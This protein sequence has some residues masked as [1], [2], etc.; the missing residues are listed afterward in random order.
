VLHL[1]Q[2]GVGELVEVER[3]ER[4]RHPNRVGGLGPAHP[5]A[6]LCYV[7]VQVTAHRIGQQ[8]HDV[9]LMHRIILS[10]IK[11]LDRVR[12]RPPK[13]ADGA[14][15]MLGQLIWGRQACPLAP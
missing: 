6:R 3:G 2:P 14:T 10:P 12:A 8:R 13:H 11:V 7:L 5:M 4:P 15:G 9:N 1:E